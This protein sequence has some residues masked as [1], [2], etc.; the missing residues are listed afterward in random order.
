M[1]KCG[2]ETQTNPERGHENVKWRDGRREIATQTPGKASLCVHIVLYML[3]EYSR[4]F[5]LMAEE[6]MYQHES[7]IGYCNSMI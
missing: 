6:Y 4:C 1:K 3:Q 2:V 7:E 5:I